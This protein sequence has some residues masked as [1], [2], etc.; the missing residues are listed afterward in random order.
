[1]APPP[2]SLADVADQLGVHYMT[3]YRY[4]R[5]GN[6]AADQVNGRWFVTPS[7]L[8]R[9]RHAAPARPGRRPRRASERVATTRVDQLVSRLVA[10]DEA[11]AWTIV[12]QRLA[13]GWERTAVV[14]ALLVPAM[15]AI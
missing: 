5:T 11:G 8:R 13:A 14:T 7:E 4:V 3:A 12:E 10:G 9:F 2:V 15:R 1:M 6:L